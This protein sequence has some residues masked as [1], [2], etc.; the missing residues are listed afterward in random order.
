M[1]DGE[2]NGAAGVGG[3]LEKLRCM[4]TQM[5]GTGF[6][7]SAWGKIALLLL[8]L[9]SLFVFLRPHPWH[10]EVPR[11]EVKTEPTPQP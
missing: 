1:L 3:W 7:L 9:S 5:G 4:T 11:L 10:M 8:L 2:V 6:S